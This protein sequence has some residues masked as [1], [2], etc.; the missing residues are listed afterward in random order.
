[1]KHTIAINQTCGEILLTQ[2]L[3]PIPDIL[4]LTDIQV[5]LRDWCHLKLHDIYFRPLTTICSEGHNR[6]KR[7]F[8]AATLGAV[9]AYTFL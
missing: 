4:N 7:Q 2:N 1:M 5:K 6:E 9:A 3:Q 8:V